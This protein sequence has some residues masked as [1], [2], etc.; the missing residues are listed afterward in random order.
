M[1]AAKTSF[2]ATNK[3]LGRATAGAGNGEEIDCTSYARGLLALS[4]A[5]SARSYLN[6]L[7]STN[8][9]VFTGQVLTAMGSV[10]TPA[11]AASNDPRTGLFFPQGDALSV[12]STGLEVFRFTS[13]GDLLAIVPGDATL[14]PFF[15]LR[16]WARFNGAAAVGASYNITA[17]Q[18]AVAS[19]YGLVGSIGDDLTTRNRMSAIEDARGLTLGFPSTPTFVDSYGRG[20]F[21]RY[22]LGTETRANYTSPGDDYHWYWNGSAWVKLPATPAASKPWIGTITLTTKTGYNPILGSGNIASI[23]RTTTGTYTFTFGTPLPDTNYAVVA[24][25]SANPGVSMGIAWPSSQTTTQFTLTCQN[26]TNNALYDP[27]TI[28]VAVIS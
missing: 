18:L 1:T 15:G 9:P 14:R 21:P 2:A 3:L 7:Q 25:I 27:S 24:S 23:N 10:G 5:P 28:G 22:N 16:A 12:V 17:N 11:I 6:A 19:R 4:D 26:A 20:T 8:N 13:T